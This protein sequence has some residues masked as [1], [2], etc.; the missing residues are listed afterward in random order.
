MGTAMHA[1]AAI[2]SLSEAAIGRGDWGRHLATMRTE[3]MSE[4]A[5]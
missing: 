2:D 1:G 4:A 5:Q 3:C